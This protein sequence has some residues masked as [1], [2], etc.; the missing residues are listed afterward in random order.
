MDAYYSTLRRLLL[1]GL[2][3]A[4]LGGCSMGQM[5]ARSSSAIME[6]GVAAMNRETDLELAKAAIP[7]NLKL[8][9]GLLYELPRDPGLRIRAAQGFYGYTFGFVEDDDPLRASQFYRRGLNHAL[10]AL[11]ALGLK[12]DALNMTPDEL[13]SALAGLPRDAV[14]AL[15]WAGSNWAKW[16]DMNRNEPAR[17]AELGKVAALMRKSLELDETYYFGGANLFFGIFYGSLP[18]MFGGDF[19]KAEQHFEKVKAVTQGK[20][21]AVDVLYAQ[22]LSRQRGDRKQFHD[23]L[24]AV[25]D[26]PPDLYPEM[27]LA[28]AIAQRKAK[29]LLKREEEWFE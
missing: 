22:F 7:A 3:G 26:A 17:V 13:N 8:L 23:K 21:L 1:I 9:E 14:P 16:I 4:L 25:V 5:V 29:I 27:A 19:N 28:N 11:D 10:V 24:T 18:R 6:S 2:C 20:L 12:G 15:F